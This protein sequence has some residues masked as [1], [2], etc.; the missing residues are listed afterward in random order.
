MRT[1]VADLSALGLRYCAP[2][3]TLIRVFHAISPTKL[4]SRA[5]KFGP[6][7]AIH[8]SCAWPVRPTA[9]AGFEWLSKVVPTPM[10]GRIVAPELASGALSRIETSPAR[11]HSLIV[12]AK[13]APYARIPSW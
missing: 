2:L 5:M 1:P 10:F 6:R 9:Y 7:L 11:P 12:L 4:D 8:D 13:L 3:F